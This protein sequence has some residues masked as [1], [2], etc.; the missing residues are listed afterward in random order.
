MLQKPSLVLARFELSF[1]LVKLWKEVIVLV[2][3]GFLLSVRSLA[4]IMSMIV[5]VLS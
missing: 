4:V 3:W 2:S 5:S 1:P